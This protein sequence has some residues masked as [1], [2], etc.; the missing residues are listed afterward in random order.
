[1]IDIHQHRIEAATR[2]V[3]IES[4]RGMRHREEVAI[5]E[6]ATRIVGHLLAKRKQALLVPFDH[7]GQRIDHD[8]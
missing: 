1:M 6:T 2:Y 5:D 4:I 7:L 3:Q 8:Q